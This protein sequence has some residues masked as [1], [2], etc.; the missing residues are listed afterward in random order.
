MDEDMNIIYLMQVKEQIFLCRALFQRPEYGIIIDDR[1]LS[2]KYVR[3]SEV[4]VSIGSGKAVHVTTCACPGS[5]RNEENNIASVHNYK[6]MAGATTT[7][8]I[9][10][11]KPF[12]NAEYFKPTEII[13]NITL[14]YLETL[15]EYY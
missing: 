1:F 13:E 14:Y 3:Y 10:L 12:H 6:I 5:S 7:S 2:I 15:D 11:V 4:Q 9:L 8:I